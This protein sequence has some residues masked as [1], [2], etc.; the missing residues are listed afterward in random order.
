MPNPTLRRSLSPTISQ[1]LYQ[2]RE[3]GRRLASAWIVE[4]VARKWRTPV[5]QYTDQAPLREVRV[6]LIL[7]DEAE[8]EP[9]GRRADDHPDVIEG[10][11][12]LDAHSHL[13]T[14]LFQLPCVKATGAQKAEV[15]ALVFGQVVRRARDRVPF[16]I[17]G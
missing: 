6:G 14:A 13:P 12:P 5:L 17:G 4:V 15:D 7:H 16:E 9:S 2:Q 10:K 1:C 3:R 8:P 11:L